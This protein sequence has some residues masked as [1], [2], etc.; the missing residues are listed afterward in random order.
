MNILLINYDNGSHIPFFPL[1]LGYLASA[2]VPNYKTYMN[3]SN[4]RAGKHHVSI[5]DQAI[6]HAPADELTCILDREEFDLVGLG[7]CAGYWQIRK[8]IELMTAINRSKSPLI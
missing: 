7:M 5:W 6:S 4:P 8:L 2:L 3:G 1:G